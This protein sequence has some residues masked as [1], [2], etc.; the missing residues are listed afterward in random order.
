MHIALFVHIHRYICGFIIR[1]VVYAEGHSVVAT[2]IGGGTQIFTGSD[3]G[4][5]REVIRGNFPLEQGPIGGNKL[6]FFRR[7]P[8]HLFQTR[9]FLIPKLAAAPARG[10]FS[11]AIEDSLLYLRLIHL[12]MFEVHRLARAKCVKEGIYLFLREPFGFNVHHGNTARFRYLQ[13]HVSY[14]G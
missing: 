11:P 8:I 14:D 9:Y 12:F 7:R 2:W 5:V 6:V 4:I 3:N 13:R 10:L 1:V